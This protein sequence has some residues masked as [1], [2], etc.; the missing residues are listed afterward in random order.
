[1][2]NEERLSPADRELEAAL[3]S[4]RPVAPDIHPM[5][6]MFE[7][8]RASAR[9]GRRVWQGLAAALRLSSAR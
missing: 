2:P 5:Q 9:T 7:A 3:A 8:G 4:L 1:M 6:M